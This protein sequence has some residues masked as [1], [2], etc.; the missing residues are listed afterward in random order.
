LLQQVAAILRTVDCGRAREL[1]M[2]A[3][4]EYQPSE[5]IQ[6]LVWMK[7]NG[8]VAR[9]IDD[10]KVTDLNVARARLHEG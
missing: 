9:P 8:I 2:A 6:D 10:P 1:L 4:R 5:Q 7:Y 3:V